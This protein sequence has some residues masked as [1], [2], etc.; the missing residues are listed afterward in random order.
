VAD[1]TGG[2]A[3]HAPALDEARQQNVRRRRKEVAAEA[4]KV[5]HAWL[6]D[7]RIKQESLASLANV[8]S[9]LVRRVEKGDYGPAPESLIDAVR[10]IGGPARELQSSARILR[11]LTGKLAQLRRPDEPRLVRSLPLRPP[12]LAG[13]EDLLAELHKGLSGGTAPGVMVL[14]GMGG[15]GKTSSALEYAH[16]DLAGLS[17]AWQVQG[18]DETVLRQG[19]AELAVQLGG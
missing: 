4:G 3:V 9:T 19:L 17:V 16:R 11:E 2:R 6:K 7:S 15:V 14:A 12:P 10:T 13:R 8:S 1:A 5:L 18:K